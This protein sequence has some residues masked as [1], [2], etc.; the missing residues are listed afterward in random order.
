MTESSRIAR[1]SGPPGERSL[2]IFRSF[3]GWRPAQIAPDTIAGLTLAAIAIPEQMATAR[4]A[5]FAPEIGFV[6]LMAGAIGF[7]IFGDSRRL[8]VGADSTIAPIFA[9]ALAGL[10]AG[11]THYASAAGALALLVG[12][13]L[14][15]A[16]AL[17]LGFVADLLSI[18]VTTGFLVGIAVHIVVSQ[19]PAILGLDPAAPGA[20]LT[21]IASLAGR[22]SSANGWTL[23]I[24]L[25]T[26]IIM[27]VGARISERL[28]AALFGLALSGLMTAALGLEA[29]GVATLGDVSGTAPHLSL[30][31]VSLDDLPTLAPLA[32]IVSLIVMVQTAATARAFADTGAGPDVNR[33]FIGVG[34]SNLIAGLT[35]AFPVDAS[36]PRTAI[37]AATGG[38]SQL[39]GLVCAA[40]ALA[41]ALF[42]GGLIAHVPYAALGGVLLFI[43]LRILRVRTMVDVWKRSRAEFLLILV[44]ATAMLALPIEE[45]VGVGVMLSLLQG[46]WT[47]TRARAIELRRIPGTSIWWP[48][49]GAEGEVAP[50]VRVIALQAPLS[51]LNA[52]VFRGAIESFA[53]G[54]DQPRLIVIEANALVEIDYTGAAVLAE[55]VRGLRQRGVDVAVARLESVR[56]QQS[57]TRLGLLTVIGPDHI[58]H[59]VEEA[60]EALSGPRPE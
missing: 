39:A 14:T 8:S 22:I 5:G 13:A 34:V 20:L 31:I 15:I 43:A 45:G 58:F 18:P 9:G 60:V 1:V 47:T 27:V 44:T 36:P 53:S 35:G 50:G 54:E 26:L 23:G 48:G 51:F 56:A 3:A 2:P 41:V 55:L 29:H 37:V 30:P 16:G 7:T 32:A 10:A 25:G 42:A 19:A 52:Y 4:L 33:D 28:P 24:G 40:L 38:V 17:R 46:V 12:L 49:E 57:F 11:N 21:Q 59:S 6:A